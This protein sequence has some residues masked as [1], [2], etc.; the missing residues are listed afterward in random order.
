VSAMQQEDA[1]GGAKP[2]AKRDAVLVID[3]ANVI[4]SRP[5]GW[6]RDRTGA[7]RQF[8]EQVR[9]AAR[10]GRVPVPAV[11]VL[12]GQARG[13]GPESDVDGVRV[14]HAAHSGDDAIVALV[15]AAGPG[16]LAVTADRRLRERVRQ[17]GA[18]T[19]GPRW[20]YDRL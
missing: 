8:V 9:S 14:V 4:G 10:Q 5:T 1:A 13:G 19:V 17:M 2:D 18:E 6:W 15:A 7:A 16:T 11:V 3:A 20:L 12:E